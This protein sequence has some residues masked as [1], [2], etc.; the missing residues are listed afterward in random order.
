MHKKFFAV[1]L[2][3]LIFC[4]SVVYA[5]DPAGDGIPVPDGTLN[6]SYSNMTLS[7]PDGSSSCTSCDG[8][9]VQ[10][11]IVSQQEAFA[12]ASPSDW[13]VAVRFDQA[14]HN[15]FYPFRSQS[16]IVGQTYY[17][18]LTESENPAMDNYIPDCY[19][20]CGWQSCHWAQLARQRCL[21]LPCSCFDLDPAQDGCIC[22]M[23]IKSASRLDG[24]HV[25]RTKITDTKYRLEIKGYSRPDCYYGRSYV[26]GEL[27]LNPGSLW[28]VTRTN[29]CSVQ[30]DQV[31]PMHTTYCQVSEKSVQF[32][33]AGDCGSC[34]ACEDSGQLNI[35]VIVERTG[36]TTPVLT[37]T[38]ISNIWERKFAQIEAEHGSAA[39]Q[40]Y[41]MTTVLLNQPQVVW[42]DIEADV[43]NDNSVDSVRSYLENTQGTLY[44][45]N[46]ELPKVHDGLYASGVTVTDL[47]QV[48][49]IIL[50]LTK[51]NMVSIGSPVGVYNW[52]TVGITDYHQNAYQ[53]NVNK[54]LPTIGDA[55]S[56][57]MFPAMP[58]S[59]N[60]HITVWATSVGSDRIDALITDPDGRRVGTI[61]TGTT[62]SE[63]NEIPGAVLLADVLFNESAQMV[64]VAIIPNA[65]AED[66]GITIYGKEQADFQMQALNWHEGEVI[67]NTTITDSIGEGEVKG[68]FFTDASVDVNPDTINLR[69]N[70]RWITAYI[71][72]PGYD[73]GTV[74]ISTVRLNE[75]IPAVNDENYGF[76]RNPKID[77]RDGDG[78]PELMVK[79]PMDD[80]KSILE[81]GSVS[82]RVAGTIS[83]KQFMGMDTVTVK[84]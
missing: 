4:V 35:D 14:D 15:Y 67:L 82:I 70:G 34:C 44:S 60:Y 28:E 46:I 61:V 51:A 64:G 8:P 5:E 56:K 40:N 37:D 26:R 18:T 31:S 23:G 45:D 24:W 25:K 36:G 49:K 3:L 30:E 2:V 21:D 22:Y 16:G 73:V 62:T 74:D 63:I 77:D 39:V 66:Y 38:R 6:I 84:G 53:F 17:E 72:V 32:A 7:S 57:Y 27:L 12:A 42:D 43:R 29:A 83:T 20:G 52:E 13:D 58:I 81:P 69:S 59:G 33:S 1:I 71:E 75:V 9:V 76:V 11:L 78:Y 79:F 80:A 50:P 47:G 68:Y 19:W 54:K 48:L 55:A 10:D 41:I 65:S